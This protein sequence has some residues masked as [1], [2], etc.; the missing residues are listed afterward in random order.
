MQ[1]VSAGTLDFEPAV[2]SYRTYTS[3]RH[4][5]IDSAAVLGVML[6]L[7]YLMPGRFIVPNLTYAGRP[8]LLVA[9][10]LFSWWVLARFN[11]WLVMVGPQPL[12]WVVWTYLL[13]FL[14]SYVA[15]TMRG[16]VTLESNAQNF[17]LLEVIEFLGVILVAADGIPNQDRLKRV[18]RL[19][20]WCAAFCA[21]T[22]IYEAVART[23]IAHF[24]K[25]PGLE[26]KGGLVG[27][28][29]RG[30]G[31]RVAGNTTHYIEFSAVMAMTVPF[32]I[33][34]VRFGQK[35]WHRVMAGV[36]G[37][38]CAAA[39]PFSISRTGILA[40]VVG[41]LL[42]VPAWRWRFRFNV[43]AASVTL[44]AALAV[45]R[46]GLLGTIGN[47]FTGANND[48]SVSARTQRYALVGHFFAEHPLFGRGPWTLVPEVYQGLVLDNQW[49]QTL[50]TQ[51]IVG[52]AALAALHLV[53]ISLAWIAKRRAADDEMRHLCQALIATQIVCILVE[54]TVDS[55]YYTTFSTTMALLMG[56][57]G[58]VWR[59]THPARTVR[60][61]T[62][63]RFV[64][65]ASALGGGRS[66]SAL[67]PLPAGHLDQTAQGPAGEDGRDEAA[68]RRA[69][70]DQG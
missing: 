18:L 33:H 26:L 24:Y 50:V 14:L 48:P 17:G 29:D 31:F 34:F 21:L 8:A 67:Q 59:F 55:F 12:R 49:L 41:L 4:A 57:C 47:M 15:G 63:R 69:G 5:R 38:I 68:E 2:V 52:V 54:G 7:L 37:L 30:V 53:C 70:P 27:F 65:A 22:G 46:P 9:L 61:S 64:G 40:L 42:M 45:L 39:V 28:E 62:V 25:I 36:S 16:L 23:D 44:V 20:L 58:A 56:V 19:L 6:C 1:P 10:L 32:A 11:P 43:L 51:G 3:R 60:T 66:A 35:R 13:S